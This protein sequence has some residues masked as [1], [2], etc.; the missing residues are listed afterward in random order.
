MQL[1][2][3]KKYKLNARGRYLPGYYC[4]MLLYTVREFLEFFDYRFFQ[5]LV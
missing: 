1:Q 4:N 2:I 3:N 5:G